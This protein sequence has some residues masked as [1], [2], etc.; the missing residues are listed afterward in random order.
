MKVFMSTAN[1]L[2]VVVVVDVLVVASQETL[3]HLCASVSPQRFRRR[4]FSGL[5]GTHSMHSALSL[6]H[7]LSQLI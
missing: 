7:S 6:E 5:L 4:V 1:T 3:D 2:V